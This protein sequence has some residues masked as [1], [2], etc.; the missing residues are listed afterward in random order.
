MTDTFDRTQ[1]DGKDRGTLS[2]IAAAVGREGGQPH[3]QGRARRR[4]IVLRDRGCARLLAPDTRANGSESAAAEEDPLDLIGRRRPRI[5]RRRAERAGIHERTG[6]RYV[7]HPPSPER[8]AG[9]R[10]LVHLDHFVL[11]RRE[12]DA[13]AD[14]FPFHSRAFAEW[15]PR[16]PTDLPTRPPAMLPTTAT[17]SGETAQHQSARDDDGQ[18]NRRR[19]RRR[20][21]IVTDPA[22]P[23][24]RREQGCQR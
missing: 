23:V 7:A 3:A 17:P 13:H 2:E 1:L 18:G 8:L 9:E 24:V 22:A 14:R 6:R 16:A 10:H 4:A 5:A 19:R 20:A 15:G 21:A 12:R 11:A